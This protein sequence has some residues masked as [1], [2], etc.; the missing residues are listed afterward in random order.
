M[1][2]YRIM[3]TS[4]TTGTQ[5]LAGILA[6]Q[7]LTAQQAPIQVTDI[8]ETILAAAYRTNSA[9]SSFDQIRSIFGSVL[10]I[11]TD[12][13]VE[14]MSHFYAKLAAGQELLDAEFSRVLHENLWDL[15][16]R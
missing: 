2:N 1:S 13:F 15:Y 7:L 14:D 4:R 9:L 8:Q 10:G 3:Q 12:R 6:T 11:G 5:V 16:E